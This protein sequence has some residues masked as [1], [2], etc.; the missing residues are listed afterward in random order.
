MATSAQSVQT[1]RV[2]PGMRTPS[3]MIRGQVRHSIGCV[4]LPTVPP[5]VLSADR[6]SQRI[7]LRSVMSGSALSL[8]ETQASRGLRGQ[9]GGCERVPHGQGYSN[10]CR[11][12][13][14]MECEELGRVPSALNTP[15]AVQG[16][17]GSCS[18]V[19][20]AV[21]VR[22]DRVLHHFVSADHRFKGVL[23]VRFVGGG[24]KGLDTGHQV[25][26][27]LLVAHHVGIVR[28]HD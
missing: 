5:P 27:R 4:S 6:T 10:A 3:E 9:C 15:P 17:A 2:L 22:G 23:P 20:A 8:L 26:E 19:R 11:T 7:R 13:Q 16:R 14:G 12:L 28:V 18:A 25:L 1:A 24:P 21:E